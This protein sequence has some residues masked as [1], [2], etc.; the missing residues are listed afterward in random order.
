M[1]SALTNDTLVQHP[2]HLDITYLKGTVNALC[3]ID[4]LTLC[5]FY[6]ISEIN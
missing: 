2:P 3:Y 5:I 4:E 6:Y 1:E